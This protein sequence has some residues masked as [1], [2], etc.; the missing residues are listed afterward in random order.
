MIATG[1]D[2]SDVAQAKENYSTTKRYMAGQSITSVRTTGY[3]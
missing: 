2:P 3:E 1:S